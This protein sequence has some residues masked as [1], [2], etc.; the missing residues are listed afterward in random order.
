MQTTAPLLEDDEIAAYHRDGQLTPRFRL[1]DE[2]FTEI[3]TAL[4]QRNLVS[5]EAT[6]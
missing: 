2:L 3:R 4:D 6:A 1:P 5:E